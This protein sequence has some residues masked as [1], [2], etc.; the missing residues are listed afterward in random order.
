MKELPIGMQDFRQIINGGYTYVDK[1]PYFYDLIKHGKNYFLSRPRRF[2][3]T[4]TCST[5][6]YLFKGEKE[7]FKDTWIYDK[8]DF[9]PYPVI[10]IS[11]TL[12][13]SKNPDT[14]QASL[15]AELERVY[16]E[17]KLEPRE[18][19]YKDQFTDLIAQLSA[20]GEVVVLIDEYDRPMLEHLG[21]PDAAH[22]IREVMR[23]FYLVVK[24]MESCLKFVLLTGL[25]KITK[26]G[27]FSALNHLDELSTKPKF[28][29]MLGYTQE[30][31]ETYFG[32][33]LQRGAAELGISREELVAQVKDYYDGFSFDGKHFVYNP[34]SILNFFDEYQLKNYWIGSGISSALTEY[35][36]IHQIKP[37]DYLNSYIRDEVLTAYEIEKAPPKS[38]LAQSG[39][40]TFKDV[41]PA[42]GY[43]VLTIP[44]AKYA[45]VFPILFFRVPIT[46]TT[47]RQT[48][49]GRE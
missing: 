46:L 34:F 7:L 8:W 37:E 44:T 24:G 2:G 33:Y 40:L 26:A 4:L 49:C 10:S 42:L 41:D 6:A 48:H 39:Y 32:E 27:V 23:E 36:R 12:V 31:L 14:V 30:E 19:D 38:F 47:K 3:K 29:A 35:I 22:A 17:Y 21:N 5:L 11:M 43:I 45:T 20:R 25:T 28:S 15:K 16:R 9:K 1:T 18:G 13:N